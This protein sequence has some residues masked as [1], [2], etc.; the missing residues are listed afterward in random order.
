MCLFLAS[1]AWLKGETRKAA[2]DVVDCTTAKAKAAITQ[3][4]PTVETVVIDSIDAA[5]QADW[6]KIKSA[7][8][9]LS[10]PSLDDVTRAIG[11]CVMQAAIN[12]ILDPIVRAGAPASEPIAVDRARLAA[13]WD[14]VR[15]KNFGGVHFKGAQ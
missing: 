14:E 13:G 11:G 3:Y 10:A 7:T 15:A 8:S 12:R 6:Q 5:G 2:A 9:G 4:A 1:C